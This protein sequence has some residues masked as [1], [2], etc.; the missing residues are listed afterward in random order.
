MCENIRGIFKNETFMAIK[1]DQVNY[2]RIC[3]KIKKF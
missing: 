1:Y 2:E 3:L